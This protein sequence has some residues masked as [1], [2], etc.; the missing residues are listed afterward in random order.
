MRPLN[1][2]N[3]EGR[4]PGRFSLAEPAPRW[5]LQTAE[6]KNCLPANSADDCGSLTGSEVTSIQFDLDH[7]LHFVEVSDQYIP[8]CQGGKSFFFA[9]GPTT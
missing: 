7:D 9:P 1:G 4:T 6:K 3:A 2:S 5:W 8:G